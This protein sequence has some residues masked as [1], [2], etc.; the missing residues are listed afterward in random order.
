VSSG[1]YS[2]PKVTIKKGERIL[3]L[4][5]PVDTKKTKKK[6]KEEGSQRRKMLDL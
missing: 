3:N 6:V 2:A 4:S 5:N 1:Q